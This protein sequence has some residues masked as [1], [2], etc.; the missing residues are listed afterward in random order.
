MMNIIETL[1]STCKLNICQSAYLGAAPAGSNLSQIACV[2]V[3]GLFANIASQIRSS[4][5]VSDVVLICLV[6]SWSNDETRWD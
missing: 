3:G 2:Q 1:R 5:D 4:Q 6:N